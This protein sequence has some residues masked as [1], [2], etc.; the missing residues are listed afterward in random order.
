[1]T[2]RAV[3]GRRYTSYQPAGSEV[4]LL[5]GTAVSTS[6]ATTQDFVAGAPLI[7]GEAVYISGTFVLPSSAASGVQPE[8]FNVI[9]LTA[10]AAD[11]A[12]GTQT[13]AQSFSIIY[14]LIEYLESELEGLLTPETVYAKI[15]E[16]KVLA[17][18]RTTSK[19]V[20]AGGRVLSG[21][22]KP[23]TIAKI[24]RAGQMIGEAT[25]AQVQSNKETVTEVHTGN[26]CGF[27]LETR[28]PVLVDDVIEVYTTEERK[29]K[30]IATE[31][32]G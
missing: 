13:T 9:G 21:D 12:L 8:V 18:F 22:L 32:H 30:L 16:V 4:W 7:Q 5:N 28:T 20:I 29:R 14:K 17:V 11:Y 6:P 15:G 25:V 3:F 19:E 1:M 31:T 2:D 10:A 24:Q 23:K 26:E 27:K